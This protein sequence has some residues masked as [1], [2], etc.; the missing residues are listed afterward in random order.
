MDPRLKRLKALLGKDMPEAFLKTALEI[1]STIIS[2]ATTFNR[3]YAAFKQS[4]RDSERQNAH[5]NMM[6]KLA[7]N[8]DQAIEAFDQTRFNSK[9]AAVSFSKVLMFATIDDIKKLEKL[10]DDYFPI[11]HR[12]RLVKR[13]DE[14][15]EERS[16]TQLS[17]ATHL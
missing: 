1:P 17:E 6:I 7:S 10:G 11:E 16:M 4:N 15:K 3:A 13:I 12:L 8:V 2:K 5:L 14:L 9:E